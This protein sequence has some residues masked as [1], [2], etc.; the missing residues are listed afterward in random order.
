MA[1]LKEIAKKIP[2]LPSLYRMLRNRYI[3]YQLKSKNTEQV[4][5]DIHRSNT[6]GGKD[7]VSGTGS[8]VYQTRIVIREL[9]AVFSDLG[10]STMLDIP[11]GDFHWMNNADLSGIEYTGAD[12]VDGLIEKNTEQYG[13]DGVRFQKLN[14]IK[15]KLPKVDLVF[16]R[17]C[18]VHLSFEDILFALDNLCKSQSEYFLT[19]TFTGR[20]DN[21]DIATGQWRVL[22]LELAPFILPTPLKI[23]NEGCTEA[24]GAYTDKALGLW[25]IADIRES[26]TRRCT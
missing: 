8:D 15:D 24:D 18:L 21:H 4:F 20:T 11:C 12:I 25:R 19:T 7:S 9:P 16:C 13:R 17:D 10:I 1:K 22:N 23:V 26:L 2:V 6:W 3:S 5:T 14:L